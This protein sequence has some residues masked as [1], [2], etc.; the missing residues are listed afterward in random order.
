MNQN[1]WYETRDRLIIE[2]LIETGIRVS[3]VRNIRLD[4]LIL[5]K[6]ASLRVFGKGRKFREL[7]VQK[8]TASSI[9]TWIHQN[10]KTNSDFLF[11]SRKGQ[12]LSRDSF[13]RITK[14]YT[15]KAKL[16]CPTL[17]HKNITPHTFRHTFA[18]RMLKS[19]TGM[20]LVS[21]WLGHEDISTTMILSLIHI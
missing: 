19:G 9:L 6:K 13:E 16:I 2:L 7:P 17:S 4:D 18:M 5:T 10:K 1:S 21:L 8:N 20:F 14:K 11:S 3:E 12:K 15:K